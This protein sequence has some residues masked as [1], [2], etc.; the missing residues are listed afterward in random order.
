[1]EYAEYDLSTQCSNLN[2]ALPL[3][4]EYL[5]EQNTFY[6]YLAMYILLGVMTFGVYK[7]FNFYPKFIIILLMLPFLSLFIHTGI[8]Q[9]NSYG[10]M[11]N[12]LGPY[13]DIAYVSYEPVDDIN[14]NILCGLKFRNNDL[15]KNCVD[16]MNNK[17]EGTCY[18]NKGYYASSAM[19]FDT[20]Y[21]DKCVVYKKREY[22]VKTKLLLSN[23]TFNN[24]AYTK[25]CVLSQ[26]LYGEDI[27]CREY[28]RDL[29][30]D[31]NTFVLKVYKMKDNFMLDDFEL[32]KMS[33][34]Y[35]L[36]SMS[37]L[38]TG[39]MFSDFSVTSLGYKKT[40]NKTTDKTTDKITDKTT[41]KTTNKTTNK[42]KLKKN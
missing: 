6:N 31:E 19:D 4:Y 28:F 1:M 40:I 39:Y 38:F 11:F 24:K 35:L 13:S 34:N 37:I 15:P 32:K 21:F 3:C 27:I 26:S 36:L 17:K 2:T 29:G 23:V 5:Q 20:V 42:T 41:D 18:E 8:S 9:Y 30:K 12:S 10:Y 25:D 7:F 33:M 22:N 14:Y 16:M